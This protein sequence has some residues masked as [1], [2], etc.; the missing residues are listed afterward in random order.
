[1]LVAA[2]SMVSSSMISSAPL[3]FRVA[4]KVHVGVGEP[5]MCRT[6]DRLGEEMV[7]IEPTAATEG[8]RESVTPA[9]G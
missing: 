8:E 9:V 6:A 2:V 5:S 4:V 7:V 3:Q 1:M